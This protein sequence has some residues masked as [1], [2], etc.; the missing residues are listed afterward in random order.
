MHTKNLPP[1]LQLYH[2]QAPKNGLISFL[3][4]ELHFYQSNPS[5]L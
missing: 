5:L 3:V 1:V 2:I 4:Y